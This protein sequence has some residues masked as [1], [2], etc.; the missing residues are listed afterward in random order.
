MARFDPD[1]VPPQALAQLNA[2]A[3]IGLL[4]GSFNPAHEA[5]VHISLVA[6]RRL[7][8][9]AVHWLVSPQ[10]PLKGASETAELEKRLARARQIATDPRIE[11]TAIEQALGTRFTVDTVEALQRRFPKARLVWLMGGDNLAQFH[12][13]RRWQE[14]ARRVP[15]A[16]IARPGYTINA[17][18]AP[19][20]RLFADAR[21]AAS[22]AAELPGKAPPA[23]VF[24]EER[25]DPASSTAL[26]QRGLWR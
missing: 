5:H 1:L 14:I 16:V 17:L 24:I 4:G 13:W 18:A 22:K 6:L 19:A 7:R 20:A 21:V 9:D 26:R 8:L 11:V 25:L 23:W 15:F 3:K 12:R 2:G 10:N